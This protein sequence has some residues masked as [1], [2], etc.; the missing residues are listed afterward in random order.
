MIPDS[1]GLPECEGT[2]WKAVRLSLRLANSYLGPSAIIL[3]YGLWGVIG[4]I[5]S[6]LLVPFALAGN[7][8][9]FEEALNPFALYGFVLPLVLMATTT[10]A[11]KLVSRVLWC[12]IP[13]P[14]TA[15]VLALAALAGRLSVLVALGYVWLSS[16]PL[17]DGLMLPE[18]M[19]CSGIAWLGLVAEWGFIR[20][21]Q[22]DFIPGSAPAPVADEAVNVAATA[23]EAEGMTRQKRKGVFTR[24]IGAWCKGRF[25]RAHR[26][27]VWIALPLGYVVVSS[28]ADDGNPQAIP[29]AVLR[30]AVITPPI[31]Q[32]FWIPSAAL[33][34]L[35]RAFSSRTAPAYH[36]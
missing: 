4:L 10:W 9:P 5:L 17:R 23:A 26:V 2:R 16:A 7:L 8:K 35:V 3:F 15:T 6:L 13:R 14:R 18:T 22:R 27:F 30:L 25:P 24:D 32:I 28:L 1:R 21:L 31:L 12:G 34:G 11:V 33:D 29:S 20:I 36:R 19:I